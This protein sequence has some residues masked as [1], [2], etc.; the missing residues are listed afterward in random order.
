MGNSW[1]VYILLSAKM[2]THSF[3]G[4][5]LD[6]L[7]YGQNPLHQFLRNKSATSWQLPHVMDFGH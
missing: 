7:R 1:P 2:H 4:N 6:K 5:C 3:N